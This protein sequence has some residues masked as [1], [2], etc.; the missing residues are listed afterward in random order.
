MRFSHAGFESCARKVDSTLLEFYIV[1]VN[2]VLGVMRFQGV[3]TIRVSDAFTHPFQFLSVK[4][5]RENLYIAGK[6]DVPVSVWC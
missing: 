3:Q 5:V 1:E 2:V 4:A 6:W